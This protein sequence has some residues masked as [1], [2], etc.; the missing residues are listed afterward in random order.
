MNESSGFDINAV[1]NDAK[2]V[3]L[4]PANFYHDMSKAGGYTE[5]LIYV[6]VMGFVAGVLATLTSIM[7]GGMRFGAGAGLFAVILLPIVAVASSFISGTVMFVIWKLMGSG[8]SFE[9]GWRCVAYSMVMF[10]IMMVL[11]W[12]P[13]LGS[14]AGVVII[15]WLMINASTEVHSIERKKAQLVLGVLG[16][17]MA[18]GNISSERAARKWEE[19]M[20]RYGEQFKQLENMSP[21]E[22]GEAVGEFLKGIEKATKE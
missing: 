22:A 4:Q 12:I 3:L 21:E 18:L 19:H 15:I 2:R 8:E 11:Q 9:T 5:P 14:I 16:L 17:F 6:V 20:E 1:I 7:G 10:P 13:Y